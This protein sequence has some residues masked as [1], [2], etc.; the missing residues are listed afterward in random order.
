MNWRLLFTGS[1]STI[2]L[3]VVVAA[4]VATLAITLWL[5]RYERQFVSR[6]VGSILTGLRLAI[7]VV[8]LFTMLQPVVTRS[9]DVSQRGRVVVGIDVS[10]SM[11]TL[12]RHASTTEKLRWAQALGM[13]GSEESSGLINEWIEALEAGVQ[14]PW[15][16]KDHSIQ[17]DADRELARGRQQQVSSVLQEFD[18]MT[19]IEFVR[20]LLASQQHVLLDDLQSVIPVDVRIFATTQQSLQIE[21]LEHTLRQDRSNLLPTGTDAV[22]FLTSLLSEESKPQLR[23]VVLLSDG[24]QTA[25]ADAVAES[26]RMASLDIPIFT[27][28]IGSRRTPRDLSIITVDC[29]ET[30]FINDTALITATLG[31]AGFEGQTLAVRLEKNGITLEQREIIPATSSTT[32]AFSVPATETGR[33]DYR[34]A[35]DVQDGELRDDNNNRD[36]SLQVVDNKAQVLLVEG[37]ARWEF[38]YLKNLLERDQQVDLSTVLFRQP[39]LKLLNEPFISSMLPDAA[40][41]KEQLAR[42]DLL[43]LGDVSKDKF[44]EKHWA[45][46]ESAV[47]SDG[48][49]LVVI[50]GRRYMPHAQS[51]PELDS[52]L[53]VTNIIQRMAEQFAKTEFD[54]PQSVFH[55]KP[56]TDGEDLPMFQL[57]DVRAIGSTPGVIPQGFSELAGHPWIYSGTPRPAATIWANAVFPGNSAAP[58]PAI[59]HQHYGFGQVVWMGIDSTWRWRHRVGDSL[60]HRFWGQLIR[61]AAR[62]KAAAGNDQVRLT[63]SDVLIDE[64]QS[65]QVTAR[66]MESALPLLTRA[67]IEVAITPAEMLANA[68]S[69]PTPNDDKSAQQLRTATLQAS[70]D[71]PQLFTGRL[72]RLPPGNWQ[73]ELKVSGG[74]VRF[75][76]P[77][78]TELFVQPHL[79]AELANVSCNRA[80]LQQ[81]SDLS[82]GSMVEPYRIHDLLT[83]IQPQDEADNKLEE[84]TLWDHW[85]ILL[86]MFTLLM[87]EWVTRKLNG[88]P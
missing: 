29:P 83:L 66:W 43:I 49:T 54:D 33:F 58:E 24:R 52:L 31:T 68:G 30:M 53:P 88:L 85:S 3:T 17:S 79:S 21:Q 44:S 75:K 15:L 62:N 6:T 35:T 60:H 69:N 45:I 9:W 57:G 5:L 63:L 64:T 18:R 84:R 86:L 80:L 72:P 65:V 59:V 12:D 47:A 74:T 25:S 14:P 55:L 1:N 51:S 42:T 61:W 36:L 50:P 87:S 41:L 81:I 2:W 16:G 4:I 70:D 71:Q 11:E 8:L 77:I 32:V 56:T 19:R 34:I 73:V 46:V 76:E 39:H 22:Q 78:V 7:L 38:R 10:D 48:L 20:R 40:S 37:D 27:V 13:L 67:N 26:K 23:G 28:P 82:G